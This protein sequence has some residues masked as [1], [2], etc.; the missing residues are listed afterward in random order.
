M[1]QDMS[2]VDA[3]A[4]IVAVVDT[5]VL[6]DLASCHDLSTSHDPDVESQRSVYRRQRARDA[7]I[8]AMLFDREG[9]ATFNLADEAREKFLQIVDPSANNLEAA[10]TTTFWHFVKDEVFPRW[11]MLT[12]LEFAKGA[13]ASSADDVLLSKALELGVPLIS[14]E[15][16]QVTG[17]RR[18]K[19]KNMRRKA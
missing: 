7:V 18:S 13:R 14:S 16:F 6:L 10:F 17:A 12:D 5:N 1:L 19:R 8:V 11:E 3:E 15:G 2:E 9:I 4:R